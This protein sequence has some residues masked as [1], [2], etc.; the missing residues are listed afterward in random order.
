[1]VETFAD[2]VVFCSL[3][4]FL[5][6][7]KGELDVSLTHMQLIARVRYVWFCVVLVS[8]AI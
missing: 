2:S 1:M 7:N 4:L 8:L 6:L 5:V 3:T